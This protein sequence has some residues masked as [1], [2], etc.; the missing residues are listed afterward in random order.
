MTKAILLYARLVLRKEADIHVEKEV[1]SS[2]DVHVKEV[3]M[4]ELQ[5]PPDVR[6][7]IKRLPS[8]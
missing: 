5:N 1:Q 4:S 3:E 8:L 7:V 6:R 2:A